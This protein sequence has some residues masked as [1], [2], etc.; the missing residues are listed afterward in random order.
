M[1]MFW[2]CLVMF[3]QACYLGG[4]WE[5]VPT[6]KVYGVAPEYLLDDWNVK[7]DFAIKAWREVLPSDC[8]AP[9]NR[10]S[11]LSGKPIRLIEVAEWTWGMSV[12]MQYAQGIDVR[13][14]TAVRPAL[15]HEL[16]HAM[17]LEHTDDV[18][19]IMR[20]PG[21]VPLP[22]SDDGQN[23]ACALGCVCF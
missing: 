14:D 9:F 12:G 5:D 3:T 1:R 19:S 18:S 10:T 7:I 4:R 13:A 23:A 15:I 6:A 8:P 22:S 11:D 20:S 21:E 17:G 2:I 16:G